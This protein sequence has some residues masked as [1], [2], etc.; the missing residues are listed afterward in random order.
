MF[1]RVFLQAVAGASLYRNK[2]RNLE[3]QLRVSLAFARLPDKDLDD[4]TLGVKNGIS[5]TRLTRRHR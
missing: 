3:M 5:V 4:F 2:E 1:P